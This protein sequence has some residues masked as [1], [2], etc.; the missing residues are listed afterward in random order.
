M[1][2]DQELTT[3]IE[4]P[5]AIPVPFEPSP[6]FGDLRDEQPVARV[7][8]PTGDHAWLVTR[9]A[10]NR[11]LLASPWLSRA[12]AAKPGA[13]R[14]RRIP[15]D[16]ES[17][18]TMD[19]PEHTR[20]RKL[21]LRA[22]TSQRVAAMSPRIE[23]RAAGLIDDLVAT[24][25]P[26]DLVGGFAEP[27]SLGVIAELLGVPATDFERFRTWSLTYLATT[28]RDPAAVAEAERQLKGYF[29]ELIAARRS[30]PADDLLS[31]L[32]RARS[33]ERLTE[34]ELVTL[35]VTLLIAGYETTASLIAGAVVALFRHPDQLEILRSRPE[36]LPS[37]V[38]ELLRY[39]P[40]AVSGGTIRVATRDIE[41]GGT[42][43][44]E[45]E[46]VLPSTTSAN[47]DGAVFD[48][49]DRLDITRDHNPH[50][51]FGHG[52]H[53]CLGSQLA[54]AEL[55]VSLR[56]LLAHFPGLRLAVPLEDVPWRLGGM[57]RRPEEL[58]IT[59]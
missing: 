26:A 3:D 25:P 16:T 1:P 4:F 54:R 52:P 27:L 55:S 40:I 56:T 34:G 5:P 46:A 30:D 14:I 11:D 58:P 12:A 37:A 35:A 8:L 51:A 10:D 23:K 45:G 19:P 53:R 24:G 7:R 47:R 22:F 59:W 42:A 28:G 48:E 13:P 57:I 20:L 50:L 39:T 31:D 2:E 33:E 21:V 49:P 43:V 41:L 44:R 36:M 9:H 17:M 29:T 38:E 15:L 32:V 6:V 18:T